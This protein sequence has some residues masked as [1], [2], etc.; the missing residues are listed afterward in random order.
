MKQF[1]VVVNNKTILVNVLSSEFFQD[2]PMSME[3]SNDTLTHSERRE[4][5][6]LAVKL[7]RESVTQETIPF[8]I[9]KDGCWEED[10][11]EENGNYSCMCTDCGNQFIGYK[12][13]TQCK[14]CANL[15]TPVREMYRKISNIAFSVLQGHSEIDDLTRFLVNHKKEWF[16]EEKDSYL[17]F[18]NENEFKII[19]NKDV[20]ETK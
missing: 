7:Y 6:R 3:I 10:Y 19:F 16:K 5:K 11:T 9:D 1:E 20:K 12:R 17:K 15:S 2:Q 18:I 4:A 14:I 13:R 8:D